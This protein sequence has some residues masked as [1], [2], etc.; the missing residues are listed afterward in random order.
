MHRENVKNLD[1][2]VFLHGHFRFQRVKFLKWKHTV[3]ASADE[4]TFLAK[5]NN[6]CYGVDSLLEIISSV[7]ISSFQD[8]SDN[9]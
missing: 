2:F 7:N 5:D 4:D 9:I 3:D 6:Y 1:L 8:G